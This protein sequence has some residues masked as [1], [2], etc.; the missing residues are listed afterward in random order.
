MQSLNPIG[1][2]LPATTPVSDQKTGLMTG[3]WINWFSLY[4]LPRLTQSTPIT[5]SK[6]Y[7][8]NT[9]SLG[10]TVIVPTAN[11]GLYRIS[12]WLHVTI[13]DNVGSS[14]TI[15]VQN[16]D[17]S[18]ACTQAAAALTSNNPTMPQGVVFIVRADAGSA[19]TFTVTYSSTGGAPKASYDLEVRAEPM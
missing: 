19:I 6:A 17:N 14:M 2:P 15:T 10:T 12:F 18:D 11:R 3:G 1:E 13:A 8:A 16:T 5:V 4:L 7:P 9:A